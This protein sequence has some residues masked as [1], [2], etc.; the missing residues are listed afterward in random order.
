MSAIV[1][2][3]PFSS[4]LKATISKLNSIATEMDKKVDEFSDAVIGIITDYDADFFANSADAETDR[5]DIKQSIVKLFAMFQ[6][7]KKASSVSG[8]IVYCQEERENV[9]NN[10]QS[11][12]ATKSQ[13]C[14]GRINDSAAKEIQE[15]SRHS[16]KSRE[17]AKSNG[18]L[19][20]EAKRFTIR[21][22]SKVNGS[23]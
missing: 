2:F 5:E 18:S 3:S 8:Y 15:S 22:V 21:S 16:A 6:P 12:I 4:A 17:I 1:K 23:P 7:E 19:K 14:L 9:K 10:P 20:K 11:K 13:R